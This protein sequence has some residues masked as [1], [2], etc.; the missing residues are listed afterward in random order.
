MMKD[1]GEPGDTA[2][3]IVG[4]AEKNVRLLYEIENDG[5]LISREW[6]QL[7]QEKTK[8]DIPIKEEYRGNFFVNFVFVKGNRS[9]QL[10]EKITVL[11]QTRN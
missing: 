8:I 5:K 1:S 3:F 11:I 6:L 7:S 9:Y 10:A 2:S 4:T